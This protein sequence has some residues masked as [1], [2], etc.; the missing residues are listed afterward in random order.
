[1]VSRGPPGSGQHGSAEEE[2][3]GDLPSS[4]VGHRERTRP[5]PSVAVVEAVAEVR[6]CDPAE[7]RPLY[8]VVDPDVLD[9]LGAGRR[10]GDGPR[11][12]FEYEGVAVEVEYGDELV[13]TTDPR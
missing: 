7:L 6:G 1:M 13:V 4:A 11:L 12:A 9:A 8:D 10:A 2:S 3:D 5:R